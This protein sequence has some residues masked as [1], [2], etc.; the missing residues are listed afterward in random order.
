MT[1]NPRTHG[2][3]HAELHDKVHLHVVAVG[4]NTSSNNMPQ[5]VSFPRFQ[6]QA[7]QHLPGNDDVVEH[8]GRILIVEIKQDGLVYAPDDPRIKPPLTRLYRSFAI[9]ATR[10]CPWNENRVSR[11]KKQTRWLP[12]ILPDGMSPPCR[13]TQLC[14][15]MCNKTMSSTRRKHQQIVHAYPTSPS[16]LRA[17]QLR[18]DTKLWHMGTQHC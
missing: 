4:S 16:T 3:E 8:V 9:S 5:H 17:R 1:G 2:K 13:R 15:R 14:L 7:R 10:F 11:I 18:S 6:E 12:R